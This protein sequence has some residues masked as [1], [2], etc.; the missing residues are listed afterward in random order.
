M[1]ISVKKK[2]SSLCLVSQKKLESILLTCG[3]TKDL[4]IDPSLIEPLERICAASWLRLVYDNK[5]FY[6]N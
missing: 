2:I 6:D 4:I 1:D 5:Y 3:E